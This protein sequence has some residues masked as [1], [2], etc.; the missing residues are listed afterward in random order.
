MSDGPSS[1]GRRSDLLEAYLGT[2]YRVVGEGGDDGIGVR[3]GVPS[4]EID[5]LLARHGARSGVFITAWNPRSRPQPPQVNDWAHRRLEDELRRLGTV[6]LQHLGVGTDPAWEP[7]HGVLA[8]DLPL[9][10]AVALA[11]AFGQNAVVVV[12]T[13]QSARLVL[14][15]LMPTD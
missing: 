2:T 9:A 3:V 4:A 12:A 6:C 11:E 5:A 10:D 1:I 13:G 14:T 15:S 8:L 7:E